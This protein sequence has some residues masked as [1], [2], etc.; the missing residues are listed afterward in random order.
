[1]IINNKQI[2]SNKKNGYIIL[3]DFFNQK[4]LTDFKDAV[5]KIIHL[6]LVKASKDQHAKINP[7]D[8]VGK[9]LHEGITALEQVDHKFISDIYDTIC[10]TPQFLRITSKAE[11][12]QCINQLTGHDLDNPMYVDQSRCRIDQPLDPYK[13]NVPWHQEIIYYVPRSDFVHTWAPLIADASVANGTIEICPGSHSE[14]AKQSYH[15][16]EGDDYRYIVDDDVIKKYNPISVEM[17]LG[18]LLIFNSKLI[19]RS[20]NNQSNQ[21]RYSLV[22]INHHISNENFIP[23]RLIVKNRDEIMNDYYNSLHL[24]DKDN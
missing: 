2:Q 6:S 4:E 15:E 5:I 17:K 24:S 19:H 13:R 20:G 1:M 21:V 3:D 12:S 10:F 11:I 23:Q 8:L 9:E 7:N 18:Q 22:G 14:I 16:G